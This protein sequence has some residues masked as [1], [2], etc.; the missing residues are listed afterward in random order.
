[1]ITTYDPNGHIV[2][3]PSLIPNILGSAE[4]HFAFIHRKQMPGDFAPYSTTWNVEIEH[5][6]SNTLKARMNYIWAK[7][8]TALVRIEQGNF[9]NSKGVGAGVYEYRIDFGPG[10]RIYFGKDGETVVIL[11]GAGTKN[12]KNTD[13]FAAKNYWHEFKARK[14]EET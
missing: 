9:S 7:V 12:H 6:I 4:S 13:I 10:Y 14:T 1:M 5:P 8:A 11:L 2:D 3:G